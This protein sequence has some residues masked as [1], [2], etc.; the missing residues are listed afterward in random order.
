MKSRFLLLVALLLIASCGADPVN[1]PAGARA[2]A[3][4]LTGDEVLSY[5]TD[6]ETSATTAFDGAIASD[7]SMPSN[8]DMDMEMSLDTTYQISDGSE[9]GSYR[10]AMTTDNLE[11][12]SGSIEM[13]NEKVDLSDLPQSQLD[14]AL[15]SQMPEFV[16]VIDDKGEVISVEMEGVAI[17]LDGLLGGTSMGGF[18]SG[19]LFGP[20][21]PDGEVKVGDTWTTSSEEEFGDIT[22]V[23]EQTHTIWRSE[24]Y[25]GHQTWVI[26]TES[27]TDGFTVTWDD[28][29]AMFEAM[30]GMDQ[31]EE[32]EG[33]PPSF[34][35]AIHA[36]PSGTTMIT[37]LDPDLGRVIAM[38]SSTNVVMTME[39][40]G[41]P[42]IAGASTMKL[43]ARTHMLMELVE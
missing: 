18:N 33:L 43:D 20:Q 37:W 28:M 30:G 39:M 24:E 4:S 34:Q 9:P 17:D 6:L 38:D 19:Q 25:N 5:H 21:L 22:V 23:T 8:M 15:D 16:Y 11:L 26:K 42:G 27:T 1:Q 7:P 31:M 13:G 10:V 40:A 36:S 3:Y 12:T 29:V 32:M 14:A 41:I 35:M 2:L